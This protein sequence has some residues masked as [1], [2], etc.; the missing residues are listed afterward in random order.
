MKDEAE[1]RCPEYFEVFEGINCGFTQC[2]FLVCGVKVVYGG[3]F[4]SGELKEVVTGRYR[5]ERWV[6]VYREF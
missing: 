6:R 2:D 3:D 1:I 4:C 5:Q